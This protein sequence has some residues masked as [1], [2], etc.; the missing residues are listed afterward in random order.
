M[1][2]F[3]RLFESDEDIKKLWREFKQTKH[4]DD[5]EKFR[6]SAL[7]AGRAD[8]IPLR[9]STP[10]VRQKSDDERHETFMRNYRRLERLRQHPSAFAT[11][12]PS[13]PNYNK[14]IRQQI[15]LHN[16][17][18]RIRDK[19][20]RTAQD[21]RELVIPAERER[22]LRRELRRVLRHDANLALNSPKLK[23][24][25]ALAARAGYQTVD[26]RSREPLGTAFK[27]Y[28]QKLAQDK[29]SVGLRN[30]KWDPS[31]LSQ[32]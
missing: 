25:Q 9:K 12:D 6:R 32:K 15:R 24:L 23:R 17:R 21:P 26:R 31:R 13:D 22:N 14:I 11:P 1:N 3:S 29:I 8:L 10:A 27:E 30:P 20:S 18:S 5:F 4:P 7:R 16:L 2:L 28:A 19:T